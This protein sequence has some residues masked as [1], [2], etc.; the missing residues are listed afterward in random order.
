MS[1]NINLTDES[2]V[3]SSFTSQEKQAIF[4]TLI[5]TS[6]VDGNFDANERAVIEDI[7]EELGLSDAERQTAIQLGQDETFA[8]LRAMD[9]SKKEQLGKFMA[10][11][12][13]ADR[14]IYPIEEK[15]FKTMKIYLGLPDEDY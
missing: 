7:L 8:V 5:A 11:V 15:F 4:R 12:I 9:D 2:S 14:K 10:R 1:K 6:G 13:Y 3:L